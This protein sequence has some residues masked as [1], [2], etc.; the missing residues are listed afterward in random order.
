MQETPGTPK[1]EIKL[2]YCYAHEDKAL[3][4]ELQV[5]LSGLKR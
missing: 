3:R 2:F 5:N 4:D 1:P